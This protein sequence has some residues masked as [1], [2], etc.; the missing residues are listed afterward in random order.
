MN[1]EIEYISLD[2][3]VFS[4]H[5]NLYEIKK[6]TNNL[7]L[8]SF[9]SL[10]IPLFYKYPDIASIDINA[11]FVQEK[12]IID[13][14]NNIIFKKNTIKEYAFRLNNLQLESIDLKTLIIDKLHPHDSWEKTILLSFFSETQYKIKSIS[15]EYFSEE[16]NL[17]ILK[18]LL[19]FYDNNNLSYKQNLKNDNYDLEF[20][21]NKSILDKLIKE[22]YKEYYPAIMNEILTTYIGDKNQK[23]SLKKV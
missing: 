20:S 9:C 10:L 13:E 6:N 5:I 12:E 4:Y 23:T 2:T 11:N 21:L 18:W 14:Q 17:H 16:E 22:A 1:E 7:T 15:Q 8:Q 19:T 3:E